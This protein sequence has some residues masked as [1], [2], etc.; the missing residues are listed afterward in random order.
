MTLDQYKRAKE[1][2]VELEELDGKIVAMEKLEP[3][4][5]EKALVRSDKFTFEIP[6]RLLFAQVQTQLA[7][8]RQRRTQLQQEFNNL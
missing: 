3:G 5:G 7:T 8:I 6:A 2:Q 4:G 1:M